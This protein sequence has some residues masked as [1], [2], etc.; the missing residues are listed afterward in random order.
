LVLDNSP[1]NAT[2]DRAFS[3]SHRAGNDSQIIGHG[4]THNVQ[5]WNL[6]C[7]PPLD[8]VAGVVS[9][10]HDLPPGRRSIGYFLL[11]VGIALQELL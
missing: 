4:Q 9:F 1:E 6:L 10:Q 3:V 8:D 7:D 5:I 11:I 2:L